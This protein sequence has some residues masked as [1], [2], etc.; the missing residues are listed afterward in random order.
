MKNFKTADTMSIYIVLAVF[1]MEKI[2]NERKVKV[3]EAALLMSLCISLCWGAVAQ[4][5]QSRLTAGIIRLHVIAE[6]DEKAEQE[7]KL[8]VRDAVTDYLTPRLAE[9]ET[10]EQAE[11]LIN[12]SIPEIESA[13]L[14]KS[15]GR[16]VTVKFGAESY[17][18]RAADGCTLPAGNYNSLRVVIG[19]G[20]GHNWWGVIFPQLTAESVSET[21]SAVSLLGEDNVRLITEGEESFAVRFK[22]LEWLEDARELFQ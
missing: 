11:A 12:A 13:A 10:P 17:G 8:R 19:P 22:V 7:L 16:P 3:W 9:C 6:S 1:F 18:T 5:R 15:E 14:S 4:A 2:K 21:G 20:E